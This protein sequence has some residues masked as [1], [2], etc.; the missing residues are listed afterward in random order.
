MTTTNARVP[1][2][3]RQRE[4]LAWLSRYIDD[5][6]YSPTVREL[7]LAFGFGSTQGAKCHLDPLRRKGW[8]TWND[9]QARTLRVLEEVADGN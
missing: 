3:D 9:G 1:L 7:C 4:I 2:T 6:G 5:H 8:V